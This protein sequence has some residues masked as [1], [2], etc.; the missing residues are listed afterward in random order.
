MQD[1]DLLEYR[2]SYP[3]PSMEELLVES[4]RFESGYIEVLKRPGLGIELK[5]KVLETIKWKG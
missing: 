1:G 4:L 5:R 2:T 3:D